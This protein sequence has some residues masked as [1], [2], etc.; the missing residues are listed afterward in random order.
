MTNKQLIL[1]EIERVDELQYEPLETKYEKVQFVSTILVY[2]FLMLLPL[3]LLL[4]KNFDGKLL[5]LIGIECVLLL[6]GIIN[7]W[8]IPKAYLF[9]GF[10]I[11]EHDITYRS[12]IIFPN[13]VTIPFC[14]VQQISVNQN[15]LTR[16]FGLY[17]VEIVNGAQMMASTIIPGLTEKRANEIKVLLTERVKHEN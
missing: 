10:A 6:A 15:P 4:A 14:K 12:G 5:V 3:L 13:I 8:L 2:A 16:M 9:K 11:R 17:A 7:L 1:N